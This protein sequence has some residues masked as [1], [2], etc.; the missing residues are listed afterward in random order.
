MSVKRGHWFKKII[1]FI[2][3]SFSVLTIY[4]M[5]V[6]FKKTFFNNQINKV[7]T[8]IVQEIDKNKFGNVL[9]N[10]DNKEDV[11]YLYID[12]DDGNIDEIF[13]CFNQ[14][15]PEY[16]YYKEEKDIGSIYIFVNEKWFYKQENILK[17][18]QFQK[19]LYDRLRPFFYKNTIVTITYKTDDFTYYNKEKSELNDKSD[20]EIQIFY[21]KFAKK[22]NYY[23]KNIKFSD[24]NNERKLIFEKE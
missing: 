21:I 10:F 8:G 13:N 7:E 20:T 16:K 12:K 6:I 4:L 24:F 17:E 2:M 18:S 22:M 19:K 23:L 9:V 5:V 14:K 1:V 11:I 15:Y 3:V